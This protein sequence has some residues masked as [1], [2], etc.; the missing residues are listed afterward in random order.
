VTAPAVRADSETA[1]TTAGQ[2]VPAVDPSHRVAACQQAGDREALRQ[3]FEAHKDRV[4]RIALAFFHGD[5]ATA[6]DVTQEVFV[7]LAGHIGQF[8][9]EAAISTYLYRLVANACV[10]EQ[11]RRKRSVPLAHE[12]NADAAA[13][14][15]HERRARARAVH[16]AVAGLPPDLR[17]AVLLRYFDELSY[18]E[19]ARALG[20]APGTV[21][22]RL[23]RGL[24]QLGRALAPWRPGGGDGQVEEV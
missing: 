7:K 15:D 24:K 1:A 13:P 17:L 16:A 3:L 23:H 11:R 20:C 4:Y 8:R 18:D 19:M 9:G 14:D 10:D 22:S 5:A 6:E 2:D 12:E 21:A